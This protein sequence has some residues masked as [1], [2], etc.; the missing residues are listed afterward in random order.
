MLSKLRG[1]IALPAPRG[2]I[3]F[4]AVTAVT[5]LISISYFCNGAVWAARYARYTID[6]VT[7][8]KKAHVKAKQTF[9]GSPTHDSV[10]CRFLQTTRACRVRQGSCD[11]AREG[12]AADRLII[13]PTVSK[14]AGR[15]PRVTGAAACKNCPLA[16]RLPLQTNVTGAYFVAYIMGT[17]CSIKLNYRV[18]RN[19]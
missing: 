14:H 4:L 11:P 13:D 7:L 1:A 17:G 10:F 2:V 6:F 12:R 5:E 16:S 19:N 3:V 18:L 9:L 15:R 8:F